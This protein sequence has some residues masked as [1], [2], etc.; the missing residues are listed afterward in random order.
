MAGSLTIVGTGFVAGGQ[1]TLEAVGAIVAAEKL[2]YLTS[3]P[4]TAYWIQKLNPSA[5]S[6]ADAYA[7]SRDR[8]DTYAEMAERLLAPARAG[9]R[10]CAAFYGHPGVFVDPSHAAIAQARREGIVARMQ[11]GISAE[12]CLFA[13][14][15]L[16]PGEFGCQSFEATDFLL[17]RRRFDRYSLLVLWQ[18][19]AIGVMDF[20]PG[21]LWSRKGLRVLTDVLLESYPRDHRITVY[22]ASSFAMCAPR[23]DHMTLSRLPRARVT[24]ASTLVVPPAGDAR[25]DGKM[26]A[27]LGLD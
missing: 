19:G 13:D 22:E 15:G 17:Y 27:L 1:A 26:L 5:E 7:P 14:L 23:L 6:L 8:G 21:L 3:D 20:R 2:F 24:V 9:A 25:L 18:I 10:V 12:D 16:D 11:P 4:L